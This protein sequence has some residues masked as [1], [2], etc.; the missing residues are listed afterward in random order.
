MQT[1]RD[2]QVV[3]WIGRLGA[4]GASHVMRQF[5]MSRSM[6]YQRLSSLTRDGLLEHH[7][8][9]YGRPGMYS[10]TLA[11]LRWQ[12]IDYLRTCSLRPG[13]FEHAWQV[14]E[15]A[16]EIHRSLPGWRVISEREI[17]SRETD[18]GQLYA[19]VQVGSV[20]DRP[21]IH[22]PDLGLMYPGKRVV[23]VEIELSTKSAPR[24]TAICRGWARARHIDTVYYLAAAGPERAVKRAVRATNATDRVTVLGLHDI[25][26]LAA[27]Q[28]TAT[29]HADLAPNALDAERHDA[30]GAYQ[31]SEAYQ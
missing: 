9:L 16:V 3:S 20:G 28:R 26:T 8:V 24:L 22:R 7:A 23:P 30:R 15:A 17:R 21:M 27:N 19:S 5:E 6:A 14:A 13:S 31:P 25:P 12:G 18:S 4:A 11:G 2:S 29:L 10:A 1:Y